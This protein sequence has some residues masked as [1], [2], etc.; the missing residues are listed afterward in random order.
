M[1]KEVE[2]NLKERIEATKQWLSGRQAKTEPEIKMLVE[3]QIATGRHL[4]AEIG[5]KW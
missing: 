1:R 3:N 2:M 4:L 5:V